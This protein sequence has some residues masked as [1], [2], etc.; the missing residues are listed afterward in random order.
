MSIWRAG[1]IKVN[2]LDECH[3]FQY[4][5]IRV[6][7]VVSAID[8]REREHS[9]VS[10]HHHDRFFKCFVDKTG[11]VSELCAR[12]GV[13]SQLNGDE[14]IRGSE[15]IV[16][17]G[18]LKQRTLLWV[19]LLVNL[20]IRYLHDLEKGLPVFNT[21]FLR[22]VGS[23]KGGFNETVKPIAVNCIISDSLAVVT[24]GV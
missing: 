7:F 24:E 10:E 12:V 8:N 13:F 21:E 2:V 14:H 23:V 11:D 18:T 16:Y 20:I 4:L 9:T 3:F 5:F 6:T 17:L 1:G 19:Y 22:W 15:C